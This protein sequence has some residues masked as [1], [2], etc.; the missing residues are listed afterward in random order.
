M[1]VRRYK[2]ITSKH[3]GIDIPADK[4]I[5]DLPKHF[6]DKIITL[7]EFEEIGIINIE[8]I[9]K[10]DKETINGIERDGFFL[11]KASVK[12]TEHVEPKTKNIG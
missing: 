7:G 8:P 2:G 3:I 11:W 9:T 12:F 4:K 5:S 10:S 6:Q 1:K